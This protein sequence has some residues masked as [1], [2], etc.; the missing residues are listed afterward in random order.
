MIN[1]SCI[2]F[3]KIILK[4]RNY[5]LQIISFII[6]LS[7]GIH[8]NSCGKKDLEESDPV[9]ALEYP[10]ITTSLENVTV[11]YDYVASI[12]GQEDVEI[13][14]QVEGTLRDIYIDEGQSVNKGQPLFKIDDD[15]L[16]QQV[17]TAEADLKTAIAGYD[18]AKME[19]EKVIPLVEKNIVSKYELDATQSSL[20][21]AEA[22]V[23]KWKSLL[24][25][26]KTQLKYS[27]VVSPSNGIAGKIFF[28]QGS[29]IS[30]MSKEPLTIISK[31]DVMYA[32][33][34]VTEGDILEFDEY[35]KGKDSRVNLSLIPEVK[36]ILP[37]GQMYQYGGKIDATTGLINSQTGTISLRAKFPNPQLLLRSGN[38]GT[39]QIPD[40]VNDAIIIP[41]KSTFEIQDKTFVFVVDGEG[42]VKSKQI[43]TQGTSGNFFII[44]KGLVSD[45]TI[46]YEGVNRLKDN[47]KI[48]PKQISLDSLLKS[49]LES[50][51]QKQDF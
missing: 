8:F 15:L 42:M 17:I 9:A 6:F 26:S 51:I 2:F 46:V 5:I 50:N 41:Q 27:T 43:V 32:Y 45:E 33:F 19:V 35:Y 11:N 25:N 47:T 34:S 13:R 31:N 21:A 7:A 39:V 38:S 14:C 4:N 22:N 23:D 10:V 44:D 28:K 3:N 12:Q 24:Q 18:K 36:L 1:K 16:R 40:Y 37:T 48:I 30:P 20:I 29:L 49:D